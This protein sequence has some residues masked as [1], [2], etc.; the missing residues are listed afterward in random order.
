VSKP[1]LRAP[2][3]SNVKDE[4]GREWRRRARRFTRHRPALISLIVLLLLTVG[5]ILAP[6]LATHDP[7][8]I[9]LFARLASPSSAHLLGTDEIGRDILSRLLYGGRITMLVGTVAAGIAIVVGVTLGGLAGFL[10]GRTD[11]VIMRVT[12]GLLSIP[13]FF[14]LLVIM[15]VFGGG[16]MQ[17]VLVVGFASWMPLARVVRGEALRTKQL[18]FVE[19]AQALG[20]PSLRIMLKH[21]VPQSVPSIIVSATL[22]VANAIL[23]ESSLS[24][25]GLGIQPPTASWGNMLNGAQSYIFNRPSMAVW[26]GIL[27]FV[28]VMACNSLGDGV[29]DALDPAERA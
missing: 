20:A 21:V 29:R 16:L 26:P 18:N 9:D 11:S 23:L 7:D 24:Y 12:D 5:A 27:I 22:G 10:G 6:L 3:P 15:A 2:A 13:L 1:V 14:F 4:S 8:S 28:V 17:I 25:L 19:A